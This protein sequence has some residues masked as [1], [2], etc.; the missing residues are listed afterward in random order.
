MSM[1]KSFGPGQKS[2]GGILVF[3]ALWII[4]YFFA[5]KFTWEIHLIF[6][7]FLF[8]SSC[9]AYKVVLYENKLAHLF[10]LFWKRNKSIRYEEIRRIVIVQS[11][12]ADVNGLPADGV[13]IIERRDGEEIKI[14]SGFV[15]RFDDLAAEISRRSG[16]VIT[17]MYS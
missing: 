7:C 14:S 8:I 16:C 4:A 5:K 13:M 2:L 10:Y 1:K 9:A 11:S 3:S 6:G 15:D 17:M 12:R